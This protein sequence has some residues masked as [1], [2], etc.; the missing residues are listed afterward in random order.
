MP[1]EEQNGKPPGNFFTFYFTGAA[2]SRK[3]AS[4]FYQ[5]PRPSMSLIIHGRILAQTEERGQ[6]GSSSRLSI[7]HATAAVWRTANECG[8]RTEDNP[9]QMVWVYVCVCRHFHYRGIAGDLR[10]SRKKR[11]MHS[12]KNS[13]RGLLMN[14]R[15]H[16]FFR[17]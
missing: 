2:A 11:E 5:L 13:I 7:Q 6:S 15:K 4:I 17:F 14:E 1:R 8:P 3:K 10:K 9:R 12:I 16:V